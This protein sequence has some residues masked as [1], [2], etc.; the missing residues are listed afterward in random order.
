MLYLCGEQGIQIEGLR[1]VRVN[2]SPALMA[3]ATQPTDAGPMR[4]RL[5]L[6][7]DG[8]RLYN[9][10]AMAP[11]QIWA[12]VEPVLDRL[13]GSFRLADVRGPTAPLGPEPQA[14]G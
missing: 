12:S 10:S 14:E 11:E 6:L 2:D 4:I 5:I 3:D 7:E 8:E 9:V 13:L 1:D